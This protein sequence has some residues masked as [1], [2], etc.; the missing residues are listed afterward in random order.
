MIILNLWGAHHDPRRW[1]EPE[2]FNPGRFIDGK[3]MF[4]EGGPSRRQCIGEQLARKEVFI[5]F[6]H[7]LHHFRFE[8][9][10]NEQF[11]FEGVFGI[12]HSPKPYMMRAIVRL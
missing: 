4:D 9:A 1:D 7:L 5:F 11:D 6:T 3:G 12:T 2:K 10:D 8:R